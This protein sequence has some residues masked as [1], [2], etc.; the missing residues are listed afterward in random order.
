MGVTCHR[1]I[2]LTSDRITSHKTKQEQ[3]YHQSWP[4]ACFL[5]WGLQKGSSGKKMKNSGAFWVLT[6]FPSALGYPDSQASGFIDYQRRS[7]QLSHPYFPLRC[8]FTRST[9]LEHRA[10]ACCWL[11]SSSQWDTDRESSQ[12]DSSSSSGWIPAEHTANL[13]PPPALGWG[14]GQLEPACVPSLGWELGRKV[15]FFTLFAIY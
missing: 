5:L 8:S 10:S 13:C 14:D 12:K 1:W 7:H 4:A 11:G 9:D 2:L 3:L 15:V 6:I